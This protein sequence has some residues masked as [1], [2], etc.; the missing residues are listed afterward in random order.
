MGFLFVL[1]T[2]VFILVCILMIAVVLIQPHEGGGL[3]SAFGGGVSD[4]FFGTKAISYAWKFTIVLVVIYFAL[5]VIINKLPVKHE[6][7]E[8]SKPAASSPEKAPADK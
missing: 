5:A 3:A 1:L 6:G 8:L 2:V 4:S 7:I